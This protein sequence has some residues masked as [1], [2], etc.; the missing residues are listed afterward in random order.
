MSLPNSYNSFPGSSN[1][2]S[3][4]NPLIKGRKQEC[5]QTVAALVIAFDH[6]LPTILSVLMGILL[7][8]KYLLQKNFHIKKRNKRETLQEILIPIWWILLLLV[9]KLGVQTKELPAVT[10]NEI[11]TN[12]V[13]TLGLYNSVPQGN[14]ATKPTVG[15]VINNVPNADRVMELVQNASNSAVSYLEF[16]STDSMADYYRRYSESRSGLQ[17]GIEFAKS[18]KKGVAYTI[19]VPVKAIPSTE[20]KLT[21]ELRMK[22]DGGGGGGGGG[23]QLSYKK[24]RGVLVVPFRG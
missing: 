20:N 16:N 18:K 11:P 22:V 17:L 24:K 13:S 6:L 4:Q 7:Q 14:A 1:T 12:N 9:I 3:P 5:T 15:Y 23:G 19:R 21:G 10:D 8:T 2:C